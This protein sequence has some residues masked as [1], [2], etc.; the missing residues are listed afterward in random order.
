MNS[1]RLDWMMIDREDV[2]LVFDRIALSAF[3]ALPVARGVETTQLI[4]ETLAR[5]RGDV[6]VVHSESTSYN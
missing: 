5:L 6:F 3:Q 4:T 1:P 2:T